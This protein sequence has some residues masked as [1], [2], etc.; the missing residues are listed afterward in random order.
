M[1]IGLIWLLMVP[2]RIVCSVCYWFG[3]SIAILHLCVSVQLKAG[4]SHAT[5]GDKRSSGLTNYHA[6][7]ATETN[8]SGSG[9]DLNHLADV[10]VDESRELKGRV[11]FVVY[12][13]LILSCREKES[14][15]GYVRFKLRNIK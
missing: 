11:F 4:T 1:A 12:V 13:C 9:R 3:L 6:K 8:S 7:R 14:K 5:C 15:L 2:E 10:E